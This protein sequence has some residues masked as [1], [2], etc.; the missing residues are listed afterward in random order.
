MW[1]AVMNALA[2]AYGAAVQM[3]D[4]SIVRVISTELASTGIED[5]AWDGRWAD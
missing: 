1:A 2:G 3:I 4:T 5:N